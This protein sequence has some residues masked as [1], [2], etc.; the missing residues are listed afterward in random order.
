MTK[1]SI[2][3][4]RFIEVKSIQT[5]LLYWSRNEIDIA[6]IKKDNYYLYHLVDRNKLKNKDYKPIIIQ[7]PYENVFKNQIKWSQRIEK[8][9]LV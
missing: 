3:N 5:V 6:R 2:I 9:D 1:N 8:Y 7:N 4:D